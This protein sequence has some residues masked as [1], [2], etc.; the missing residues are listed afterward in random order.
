[1]ALQV[2]DTREQVVIEKINR[3]HIVKYAGA[4]GDFNP[5][6]HDEIFAK[7]VAGYPRCS[8]T[9]CCRWG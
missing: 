2:G 1:M 8:P 5:I 3:T 4:S 9:G 6:H 7:E